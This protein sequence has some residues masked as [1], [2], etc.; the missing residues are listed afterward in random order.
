MWHVKNWTAQR[1]KSN[2]S[3]IA[4]KWP[5]WVFWFSTLSVSM[6]FEI[7]HENVAYRP[8][9]SAWCKNYKK[10][11]GWWVPAR[12]RAAARGRLG[13]KLGRFGGEG[14]SGGH[15]FGGIRTLGVISPPKIRV[16]FG[17]TPHPGSFGG[18][19][20]FGFLL[21]PGKST[22]SG[23]FFGALNPGSFL[24]PK[25]RVPFGLGQS[26]PKIQVPFEAESQARMRQKLFAIC[27][28]QVF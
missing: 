15:F 24:G 25:I 7:N 14:H 22:K 5:P 28:H 18:E 13:E 21:E 16:P 2:I 8:Y 12:S 3:E 27:I 20:R 19:P 23:W 1:P 4:T 10:K 26:G 17:S 6:I 11:R 9:Q